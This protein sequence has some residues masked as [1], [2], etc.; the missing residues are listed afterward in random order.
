MTC[1]RADARRAHILW[2]LADQPDVVCAMLSDEH[3]VPGYVVLTFGLRLAT[4][5]YVY[6]MIL[7]A[8]RYDDA[9]MVNAVTEYCKSV[10]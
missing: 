6:D 7:P 2:L 3:D 8:D 4:G 10:Q 9:L 5:E 1:A